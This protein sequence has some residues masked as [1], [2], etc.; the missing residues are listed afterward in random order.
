MTQPGQILGELPYLAT[1]QTKV[2]ATV[3]TRSDLYG[4]GTTCYALLTGRPQSV[5]IRSR[6]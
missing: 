4:L 2:D 1:E 3:D 5:V 6:N